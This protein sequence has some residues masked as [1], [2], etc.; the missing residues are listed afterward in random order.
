MSRNY[1]AAALLNSAAARG[2]K[3]VSADGLVEVRAAV[4]AVN[5]AFDAFKAENDK[6]L[7]AIEAKKPD[8]VIDEKVERINA[9]IAKLQKA[10]DDSAQQAAAGRLGGGAPAPGADPDYVRAFA[11]WFRSG[12][13]EDEVQSQQFQGPRAAMS[14]G[15]NPDG[16]YLAP[17]EWD[18]TITDKLKLISAM[19]GLARVQQVSTGRFTRLYNDRATASGWVGETAARPAT[20]NA[21][22]SSLQFDTGEVYANPSATQTLLDDA[23]VN[24][25]AWLA[26]EVQ[27]EFAY[28]EG[29][30]F[31]SGDGANKPFGFL[32]YVT[33]A[34]NAAKHPWGAIGLI[35]TG[36]AAAL[37]A[38]GLVD[39]V[40]A[41]PSERAMN[42]AFV[43]NR[44]TQGLVRKLKDADNQYLWR[45]GL[46]AGAPATLLGFPVVEMPAM[47]NVA[48]GTKPI[49]LGDFSRGYL[50]VDRIGVRV[51][52]DPYTSKPNILFYTT[53]RV[54]GGVNDPEAIKVQNVSA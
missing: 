30:A 50:I 37:T 1:S 38:D 8:P 4:E 39:L 10:I 14:V 49:A 22:L 17:I 29:V 25:D 33:G 27:T 32:T 21:Q 7:A 46:E 2:L 5:R 35:N 15:S 18:R 53:K 19:R 20:G 45:P 16:G 47:P 28:Q 13:G 9:E 23:L 26:E 31:V 52:R 41:L 54:G 6:R 34:A 44:A 48:A 40:Y 42:A 51:L 11:R 12:R 24:V 43:M 36:A 3:R